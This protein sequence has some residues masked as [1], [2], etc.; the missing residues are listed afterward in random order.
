MDTIAVI[1]QKGGAGKTTLAICLAT[2]AA[3]Q[4]LAT[5]IIDSDQQGTASQWS[6]WRQGEAPEVIRCTNKDQIAGKA[7]Q[8]QKFGADIVIIDTPPH[9]D[10]MAIEGA[11]IADLIL[12]PCKPNAFDL[13]AIA[14]SIDLA[15]RSNKQ[16]YVVFVSG[17]IRGE[18]AYREASEIIQSLYKIDI[19]PFRL[20]QR[21]IYRHAVAEGKTP[22]D[23]EPAGKAAI[24]INNLWEWVKGTLKNG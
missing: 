16:A 24:E 4:G 1:S 20:P 5:L 23:A 22:I 19:A 18:A 7:A 17:E 10:A 8:A 12:I 13:A 6:E 9:A 15:K 11:K 2:A 14:Q 3:G 21:A